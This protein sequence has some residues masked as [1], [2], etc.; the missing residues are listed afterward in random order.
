MSL[1]ISLTAV[2]TTEVF[3]CNITHNL[4][5]MADAVG[6][7]QY[8]W[9]PEELGITHA[10]DLIEPL[11][12]GLELLKSDPER[13]R[14]LEPAN[15]WGTYDVFVPWIKEYLDACIANPDAEVLADR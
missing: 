15:K 11:T 13:F 1:H 12:K 9:R 8:L 10:R 4:G 6:I 3:N 14:K 5:K 2:R 7:Y